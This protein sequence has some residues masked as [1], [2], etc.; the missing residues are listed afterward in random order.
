MPTSLGRTLVHEHLSMN[1]DVAYVKPK[2]EDKQ[3]CVIPFSM[4][5]LGWIRYN[6]Y[7][8]HENLKLNDEECENCIIQ[9]L[10]HYKAI[11][12]DCIVDCTSHGISR[13]A[14]FLLDASLQT[15]V[16][17]VSGTGYYVA[18]SQ[19]SIFLAEPV[20][21]LA[22]IMRIEQLEGCI[23]TPAVRC[24]LIGEIGCSYPLHRMPT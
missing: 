7:S 1:F 3:N 20:E 9:E 19:N 8:H 21:K 16:K 14:Q 18:A 23:E 11:G 2:E 10:L 6:P 13:K 22:E 5:N 12:G 24:G 4:K 17:I 15:G